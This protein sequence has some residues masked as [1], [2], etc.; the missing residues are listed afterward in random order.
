MRTLLP[1]AA[2]VA[3]AALAVSC[4]GG[5]ES[6]KAVISVEGGVATSDDGK[7]TLDIPPGALD[8]E[9]ELTISAVSVDELPEAL[10][11]ASGTGPAYRLE[12]DGLVFNE[13]VPVTLKLD[14]SEMDDVPEDGVVAHLLLTRNADGEIETLEELVTEA[15]LGEETITV[16]GELSHFSWL[17]DSDGALIVSLER[18]A[19]RQEVDKR[20]TAVV[21]FEAVEF[22]FIPG[23]FELVPEFVEPYG[24]LSVEHVTMKGFDSG[25]VFDIPIRLDTI[26]AEGTGEFLR[27][28][29]ICVEPDLGVYGIDTKWRERGGGGPYRVTIRA[30]VDCVDTGDVAQ[31]P[32]PTSTSAPATPT[33]GTPDPHTFTPV[34]PPPT[35]TP[36]PPPEGPG[37]G[38]T[39]ETTTFTDPTGDEIV[40]GAMGIV[41]GGSDP[42][43]DIRTVRIGPSF[44]G[45][46][47][48]VLVTF[49]SDPSPNR[50]HFTFVVVI[51]LDDRAGLIQINAGSDNSTAPEGGSLVF[52]EGGVLMTFPGP[53]PSG[54]TLSVETIHQETENSDLAIDSFTAIVP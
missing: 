6:G 7:L 19:L 34:P 14:R 26:F 20:F 35:N 27:A 46:G 23:D 4:G 16:R 47:T 39:P 38:P 36:T 43:A 8:E 42:A 2:I 15:T 29:Y 50:A 18:V 1:V 13:P 51:A 32:P 28:H 25:G 12:P 22:F 24:V 11:E 49:G 30:N 37:P 3:F 33:P 21:L 44:G 5:G 52:G 17:T 53:V 31:E 10:R 48:R 40:M 45:T 54:A 9:V 41:D